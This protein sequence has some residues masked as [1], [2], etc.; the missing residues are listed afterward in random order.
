MFYHYSQNNSG[1]QF[2]VNKNVCH[3]VIIEA[4]SAH[5]ANERAEDLGLY[6]N[7]VEE[8]RDCSCCGDRWYRV[9]GEGDNE[10]LIYGQHP[11]T[12]NNAFAEP[13]EVHCRVFYLDGRIAEYQ[14]P[15]SDQLIKE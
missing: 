1:G 9:W 14:Q 10:P 7:G 13:G 15:A 8:G 2:H 4:P 6:F 3:D 5:Q 12:R 11:A